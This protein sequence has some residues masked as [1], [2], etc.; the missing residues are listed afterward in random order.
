MTALVGVDD[1]GKDR[2]GVKVRDAHGL[3][4]PV[5]RDERGGSKVA[6]QR[7]VLDPS[8]GHAGGIDLGIGVKLGGGHGDGR[9]RGMSCWGWKE[10][11]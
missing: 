11:R 10:G 2:G 7:V 3:D 9:G 8:D 4:G 1:P 6:D 5:D